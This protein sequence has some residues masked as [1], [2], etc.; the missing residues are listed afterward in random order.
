MIAVS[1]YSYPVDFGKIG[2]KYNVVTE[3][4]IFNMW[5]A[6][7]WCDKTMKY[8]KEIVDELRLVR[9]FSYIIKNFRFSRYRKTDYINCA[10]GVDADDPDVH[11]LCP[12]FTSMTDMSL[13]V[14]MEVYVK[15]Q[16]MPVISK[17]RNNGFDG[18]G[19]YCQNVDEKQKG[20]VTS[21]TYDYGSQPVDDADTFSFHYDSGRSRERVFRIIDEFVDPGAK[22]M[23]Q[24]AA[25]YAATAVIGKRKLAVMRLVKKMKNRGGK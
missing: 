1:G 9:D 14:Y 24:A 8:M 25:K 23:A 5:G 18:S 21:D 19:E 16:V 6:G 10:A 22:M 12:M 20:K 4:A 13:G 17:V 2:K 3:N 11:A 7:F 15:Y